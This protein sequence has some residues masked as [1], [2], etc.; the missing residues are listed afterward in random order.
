M[1]AQK[2]L[3]FLACDKH[4]RFLKMTIVGFN[5]TKI[6]AQRKKGI[7][8][9]IDIKN[10]VAIIGIEETKMPVDD[11]RKALKFDF[12]FNSIY[13]PEFGYIKL[14]GEVIFIADKKE[15][16][17]ALKIWKKDK[18]AKGEF[19]QPIMN[20]ILAKSNVEAV[21]ISRDLNLPTP[22]PLPKVK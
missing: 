12:E 9:K 3:A 6:D 8:G 1:N 20:N 17:E 13:Q 22:I 16:D 4:W 2:C 11:K 14:A 21:I 18:K 5:F 19:M 15:A 10:N 7:Q